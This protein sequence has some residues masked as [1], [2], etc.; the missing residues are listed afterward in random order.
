VYVRTEWV[1]GGSLEAIRTVWEAFNAASSGWSK[2]A[3]DKLRASWMR[4]GA[5]DGT[6][7][8]RTGEPCNVAL[9]GPDRLGS[10]GLGFRV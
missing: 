4:G 7:A 5:P 3:A 1:G 8:T 6:A 9:T 2:T 10:R